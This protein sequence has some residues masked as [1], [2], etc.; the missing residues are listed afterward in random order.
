MLNNVLK[1]HSIMKKILT[2]FLFLSLGLIIQAQVIDTAR[3][4][5]DYVPHILNF[6]KINHTAKINDTIKDKVKFDYYIT[7][8]KLEIDFEPSQIKAAKM[9]PDIL[10]RLYRNYVKVGFGYPVTPLAELSIHN[11]RN[12]NYSYGLNAHHFS[13]WAA[14][15]GKEMKQYANHPFSDTKTEIYFNRFFRKQTLYSSIGYNHEAARL[16][17]FKKA[18]FP[19]YY[20]GKEYK[21]SLKNNF[22]HLKAEVGLRSNYTL[23]EKKLKQDVRLNYDFIRTNHKDMENRIALTSFLAYDARF[24]KIS[25]S[26]HY[27]I[28]VDFDYTNNSWN[29][30][31]AKRVDH[32]IHFELK[33]TLQFAIKEYHLRV[34]L[35]VPVIHSQGETKV[36]LYPIA[37]LQLGFIPGIMSFYAG[38]DGK[39]TYN[40]LSEMLY[41]NPYLKS[42]LD[43]IRFTTNPVGFNSVYGGIK[44]NLVKKLNYHLSV[45]YSNL[46]DMHFFVI[47]T[48]C[49]LKNQFD[50][51]Y[52]DGGMLNAALNVN[53]EAINNLYL[54]FDA[55][56]WFYHFKDD[57][58]VA[59][60]KPMLDFAFN[61]KYVLKEKMIFG[62]NFDLGFGSKALMQNEETGAWEVQKMKPVLDFGINFEYLIKK[63]FSAFVMVNNVACQHYA[64][65]YNFKNFGINAIVGVT[66]SFGN[67]SFKRVKGSK[68]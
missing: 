24:M 45:R 15:I 19:E 42:T 60:H 46:K 56:F 11:T 6:Q 58:A 67:E 23:E 49:L 47:D 55:N 64:K 33:P 1:N 38:V 14:P 41:E 40:S 36:P 20:S 61:G 3:F 54:N 10:E 30:D 66:Y 5:L 37:E 21:D 8:Q 27:R 17:G 26:Q 34:G 59:W 50:V 4:R 44:G 22:H 63:N 35:G 43:P 12:K 48:T 7:P 62:L 68:N 53:W 65:Y 13:Y 9:T 2:S 51:V 39:I 32:S 16:Y 57:E 18:D 25:G 31:T 52:Y 28:D 29:L